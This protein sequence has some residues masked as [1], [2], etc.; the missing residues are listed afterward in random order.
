M[1]LVDQ[2]SDN[3]EHS[4]YGPHEAENMPLELQLNVIDFQGAY[5]ILLVSPLM[6]AATLP[7]PSLDRSFFLCWRRGLLG[8]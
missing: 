6:L 3:V 8:L 7:D 1:C 2:Y 5:S 4:W